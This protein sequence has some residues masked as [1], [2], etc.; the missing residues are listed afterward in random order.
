MAKSKVNPGASN[1][2]LDKQEST[3]TSESQKTT[4]LE[5]KE[6]KEFVKS[7][8]IEGANI[9]DI[10]AGSGYSQS[11]DLIAALAGAKP[12]EKKKPQ[13]TEYRALVRGNHTGVIGTPTLKQIGAEPGDY[14]KIVVGTG[15]QKGT[16][17]VSVDKEAK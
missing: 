13:K 9:A 12:A 3:G 15:K 4:L 14:L 5:G 6:L 1:P 2:D 7:K 8:S 17:T 11:K 10:L 16:L